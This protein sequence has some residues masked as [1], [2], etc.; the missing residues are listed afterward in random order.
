MWKTSPLYQQLAY[1]SLLELWKSFVSRIVLHSIRRV[2]K[3]YVIRLREG[4]LWN[5]LCGKV[6]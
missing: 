6:Y 2:I 5:I 1:A 3:R 4:D